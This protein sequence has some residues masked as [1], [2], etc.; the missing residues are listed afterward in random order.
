[1]A[2]SIDTLVALINRK[3]PLP[4]EFNRALKNVV[5]TS[6]NRGIYT[7]QLGELI[8]LLKI[9]LPKEMIGDYNRYFDCDYLYKLVSILDRAGV[10][11]LPPK[12]PRNIGEGNVI[13][14]LRKPD[15][16]LDQDIAKLQEV[17]KSGNAA[18]SNSEIDAI[19]RAKTKLYNFNIVTRIFEYLGAAQLRPL[20]ANQRSYLNEALNRMLLPHDCDRYMRSMYSYACDCGSFNYDFSNPKYVSRPMSAE[21]TEIILTIIA[22]TIAPSHHDIRIPD[23]F[24]YQSAL[25]RLYNTYCPETYSDVS[26]DVRE[27]SVRVP[28]SE[29]PLSSLTSAQRRVRLK[30]Y[31]SRFLTNLGPNDGPYA[32]Q[33]T[34]QAKVPQ[35]DK[36]S[37]L[38]IRRGYSED[39][40]KVVK[41]FYP[42]ET[43]HFPRYVERLAFE[44]KRSEHLRLM[45]P[46]FSETRLVVYTPNRSHAD[47]VSESMH[48]S[49][50]V[51]IAS[52]EF[53]DEQVAELEA[54][55]ATEVADEAS[56]RLVSHKDKVSNEAPTLVGG[57]I[58]ATAAHASSSVGGTPSSAGDGSL[59]L[60]GG[61]VASGDGSLNLVGGAVGSADEE[62]APVGG[63]VASGDGSLNLGGA[64]VGSADEKQAP[65]GGAEST[66]DRAASLAGGTVSRA[67]DRE[68]GVVDGSPELGAVSARDRADHKGQSI[69]DGDPRLATTSSIVGG[70][71]YVGGPAKSNTKA[72]VSAKSVVPFD[73][74]VLQHIK[75]AVADEEQGNKRNSYTRATSAA[76][77]Y[78][79]MML[80]NSGVWSADAPLFEMISGAQLDLNTDSLAIKRLDALYTPDPEDFMRVG[81][82]GLN[83][84]FISTIE[85]EL[86]S[87]TEP[88]KR[89]HNSKAK[90]G[91]KPRNYRIVPYVFDRLTFLYHSYM[92][93]GLQKDVVLNSPSEAIIS[94]D[95]DYGSNL[96]RF[97]KNPL[98]QIER[99]NKIAAYELVLRHVFGKGPLACALNNKGDSDANELHR[100]FDLLSRDYELLSQTNPLPFLYY[101]SIVYFD[102]YLQSPHTHF[103]NELF[104][105]TLLSKEPFAINIYL[106]RI[107]RK[108]G[109]RLADIPKEFYSLIALWLLLFPPVRLQ[110]QA[111]TILNRMLNVN[112]VTENGQLYN[113]I[114][115]R[116][117]AHRL[118]MWVHSHK[119][120]LAKDLVIEKVHNDA[121]PKKPRDAATINQENIE[122]GLLKEDFKQTVFND[123]S[124][125]LTL[126]FQDIILRDSSIEANLADESALLVSDIADHDMSREYRSS[127]VRF[128]SECLKGNK[129]AALK[130]AANLISDAASMLSSILARMSDPPDLNTKLAEANATIL[131]RIFEKTAVNSNEDVFDEDF[132]NMHT[133]RFGCSDFDAV[134]KLC[135]KGAIRYPEF[136]KNGAISGTKVIEGLL[137]DD[138]TGAVLVLLLLT[139]SISNAR[140]ASSPITLKYALQF[141]TN[142]SVGLRGLVQSKSLILQ[143]DEKRNHGYDG[144]KNL[145]GVHRVE[146]LSLEDIDE[147]I[148]SRL[149]SCSVCLSILQHVEEISS[150]SKGMMNTFEVKRV[151][152]KCNALF[153]KKCYDLHYGKGTV[154]TDELIG[155]LYMDY[156]KPVIRALLCNDYECYYSLNNHVDLSEIFDSERI[157]ACYEHSCYY[158]IEDL[159]FNRFIIDSFVY[160][161][162]DERF[163]ELI[164]FALNAQTSYD[165]GFADGIP[166]EYLSSISGLIKKNFNLQLVPFAY[167]GA[168][169]NSFSVFRPSYRH[170]KL[171]TIPEA[172]CSRS[173]VDLYLDLIFSLYCGFICLELVHSIMPNI[174][175]KGLVELLTQETVTIHKLSKHNDCIRFIY[176]FFAHSDHI[177]RLEGPIDVALLFDGRLDLAL[178]LNVTTSMS[179]FRH[180]LTMAFGY[181]MVNNNADELAKRRYAMLVSRFKFISPK[182]RDSTKIEMAFKSFDEISPNIPQPV[183]FDMNKVREKLEES[184]QVQDVISTLREKEEAD[185]LRR[186]RIKGIMEAN[187]AEASQTKAAPELDE[188]VAALRLNGISTKQASAMATA[189]AEAAA[190]Y[191]IEKGS[192]TSDSS[193]YAPAKQDRPVTADNLDDDNS[194]AS[195][196]AATATNVAGASTSANNVV[197][198]DSD[199]S[200]APSEH[201]INSILN[202]KLR[203]VVGAIAVQGTDAMVF[204]EFN[205]LCVSHGLLSGNYAI[206][207]L[208]NYTFDEYDGPVLELDGEG[209]SA[210][211]Y[212]DTEMITDMHS[213]CSKS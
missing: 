137:P 195:A 54:T 47:D 57:V 105:L 97:L 56:S 176:E 86:G 212:I 149:I 14:L 175:T 6:F 99:F 147:H 63:A 186:E 211:V 48:S 37:L 210:I 156:V 127:C 20:D 95:E 45:L 44:L 1:M 71:A 59:N 78:T 93:W 172:L 173:V 22:K 55:N 66:T 145:G 171:L 178:A 158:N 116:D 74:S 21:D 11:M 153:S 38:L 87:I 192:A 122:F 124:R 117:L 151:V 133:K 8:A 53:D 69:G 72:A 36:D 76:F 180:Y 77:K 202:A 209:N 167:L 91:T 67:G 17:A 92:I 190:I 121:A 166:T 83:P 198:G 113:V 41:E 191:F 194:I 107:T 197:S 35:S 129:V 108:Y 174:K 100:F 152:C 189:I 200:D 141:I 130:V 161:H 144:S 4:F 187:R 184:K 134:S 29:R 125:L 90:V 132:V 170:I 118:Y 164:Q 114:V 182:E 51:S 168:G 60:V 49:E 128:V 110:Q 73:A 80:Q 123:S 50:Y 140:L 98:S 5:S 109:H 82:Q 185:E 179:R 205:G 142:I 208:N 70:F 102:K 27:K 84:S 19:N 39:F 201:K 88:I 213:H 16:M 103:N 94:L 23:D 163:A 115:L 24:P 160:K 9:E 119:D 65:V 199:S 31:I 193:D 177:I 196:D 2:Y 101:H 143:K 68:L 131:N 28:V 10:A 138:D 136:V 62:H 181:E 34:G 157:S 33:K 155:P 148:V 42:R 18:H 13:Y 106:T 104:Y 150:L 135:K 15:L 58:N 75:D 43:D 25:R 206:E 12:V 7:L 162:D 204:S 89:A 154:F 61:A 207:E 139:G 81:G 85:N 203:E 111:A 30:S 146:I 188:D 64:A 79:T 26:V 120:D 165:I 3:E 169:A 52:G 159:S 183:K 40:L 112:V 46:D 32:H 96:E 126:P